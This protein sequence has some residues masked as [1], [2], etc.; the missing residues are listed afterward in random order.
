[1]ERHLE[2][3]ELFQI[4]PIVVNNHLV[5]IL[6]V[7]LPEKSLQMNIHKANNFTLL[8]P[9][10]KHIFQYSLEGEYLTVTSD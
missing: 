8:Y 1:M 3:Y 4:S 7:F 6:Q 10:L 5:V 2:L 9:Q